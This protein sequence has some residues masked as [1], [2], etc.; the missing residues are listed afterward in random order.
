MGRRYLGLLLVLVLT[1]GLL[2]VHAA[3]AGGQKL[4]A[5]TFDDGPGPYTDQL[6]DELAKRGVLVTFF[7]QGHNASRY[8]DVVKKAYEA[9]HQIASHTYS[10]PQL[11]KLTDKDILGELAGAAGALDRATGTRNTYMLRPPYGSVDDRVL[12]VIGV[13]AILW[14]VDTRDWESHSADAIYRHIVNDTR[15]GSILLL[16][17]IHAASI[18]GALRGIDALL[19]QGYELVTVSEL[20]R[21]RGCEAGPGMK[22]YSAPGSVTLPA[23]AP[24]AIT[25]EAVPGGQRVTLTAEEG[26]AIYYTTDGSRPAS[27]S[28]VYTGPF[29]LEESGTVRAFAAYSLNGGRGPIAEQRLE[30]PR[31]EAPVIA[32]EGETAVLSAAGEVRYTLDGTAPTGDSP[33]YEGPVALP[34]GTL[35]QAIAVASGAGN[36][37]VVSL[38]R[39]HRG[40]LFADVRPEAWYYP[41]VDEAAERGLLTVEDGKFYPERAAVRRELVTALYRLAGEPAVDSAPL[42]FTDVDEDDRAAFAWAV[43]EGILSGFDDGTLRPEGSLTREQL[44]VMLYRMEPAAPAG[45]PAESGPRGFADWEEIHGYALDAMGWAVDGGLV[46]GVSEGRLAPGA[47]VTRA[48]LAGLILRWQEGARGPRA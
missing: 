30:V 41:A 42:S 1:M 2:P 29:L 24:P 36:S 28:R 10:H 12:S 45:A 13:P 5:I 44:V 34:A 3:A 32:V 22:Y 11:T 20:L 4:A 25:A 23:I 38:L 46:K 7:M 40:N 33:L 43:G 15:D 39:S 26:A 27:R 47:L 21:R 16:H 48:Q 35:L 18:P 17:D 9:G 37:P 14:S 6:L 19:E 8:P 31:A